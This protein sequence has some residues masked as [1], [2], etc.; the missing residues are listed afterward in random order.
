MP[1]SQPARISRQTI[2]TLARLAHLKL[3]PAEEV[4]YQR[5]LSAIVEFVNQLEQAE[6]AGCQP[7]HQVTGLTNRWRADEIG[8]LAPDQQP[9]PADLLT[10]LADRLVDGQFKVPRPLVEADG[11]SD[12]Q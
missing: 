4:S 12:K 7:L 11:A 1:D 2:K 6:V 9:G 10:S 3:S 5:E 8:Q